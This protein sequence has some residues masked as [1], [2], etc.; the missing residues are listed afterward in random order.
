MSGWATKR[1]WEAAN[2]A[3]LGDGFTV[4]LDGR[5][6]KT[7]AKSP[8]LVPTRAMADAIAAEWAAQGEKINPLSMPVT[9]S[10]NAA[11]DKVT[12]QHAEVADM[13]AAY[14]DAEL[15]CYRAEYPDLLIA[16]Q[17]AAWDPLLDW[18][19]VTLKARL[20]PVTGL[21]H[22]PQPPEALQALSVRVHALDAFT[23]AAFHDLVSLSGSLIIGFA[24]LQDLRPADDLWQIS[25]IDELW[26]QEEWGK[27]SEAQKMAAQKESAY[28]HAKFFCNIARQM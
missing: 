17:A 1:F 2:V 20:M 9:R 3:T 19:E 14:G 4:H 23:L 11:I 5:A 13:I 12:P 6:V 16:R 18:A 15:I 24:T 21:M 25:R 27:D 7:P 8:L 26:Q 28:L 22:A 10:A